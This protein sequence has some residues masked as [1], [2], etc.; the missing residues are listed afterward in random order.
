MIVVSGSASK[1]LG[2]SFSKEVNAKHANVVIKRFPDGEAYVRIMDNLDGENVVLIQSTYPDQNAIEL[3]L[4]QDAIK[5][6]KIKKLTTV[7]PYFGYSRQDKKFNEGEPISARA[8]AKH[9]GMMSDEVIT[10]DIHDKSI[11]RFFDV[12]AKDISGMPQIAKYFLKL[13]PTVIIAPDDGASGR[14]KTVAGIIKCRWDYLEKKRIDGEHVEIAPKSVSAKGE[15]IAIVDDIIATGGT[16]I[17]AAKQLKQQGAEKIFAAC[18]HGL[19]TG[20]ATEKLKGV[21]DLVVSTDTIENPTTNVSVAKE[22][23]KEILKQ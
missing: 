18:T 20:G 11:L 16:I 8:M 22:I 13:K 4:L 14:A 15:K 7:I 23:V 10:I 6:F 1:K 5:E 19:F 3:F 17:A 21:C 9:V 12:N 2:E